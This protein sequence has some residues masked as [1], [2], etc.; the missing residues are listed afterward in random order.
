[1]C[2]CRV[3]V[4]EDSGCADQ[5]SLLRQSGKQSLRTSRAANFSSVMEN[6]NQDSFQVYE[7]SVQSMHGSMRLGGNRA[8]PEVLPVL[9]V[10]EQLASG[11]WSEV[12]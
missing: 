8:G 5:P 9:A 6:T 7:D 4:Y 12:Q 1:M 3:Q 10:A 11:E 2:I